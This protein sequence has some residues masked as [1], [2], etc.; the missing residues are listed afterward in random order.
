ML[1]KS[2][3]TSWGTKHRSRLIE[4]QDLRSPVEHLDDLD[5]LALTHFELFDEVVGVDRRGRMPRP[6]L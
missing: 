6:P 3:S 4:D 5:P 1:R 2:S